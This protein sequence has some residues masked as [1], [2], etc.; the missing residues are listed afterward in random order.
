MTFM[1]ACRILRVSKVFRIFRAIRFL[2]ELR[3]MAACV[4][5]SLGSLF[6]AT[7]FLSIMLMMAALV[8]VQSM[9]NF[10]MDNIGF[11]HELFKEIPDLFGSVVTAMIVLFES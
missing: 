9:A 3:L 6:W 1:R 4:V 7:L 10:Q 5:G 8:F 2:S 11:E